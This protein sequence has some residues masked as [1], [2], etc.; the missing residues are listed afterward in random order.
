MSAADKL[1]LRHPAENLLLVELKSTGE[2]VSFRDAEISIPTS[3]S[4]NGRLFVSP[5]DHLDALVS[6]SQSLTT[7]TASNNLILV[8]LINIQIN[9]ELLF[10]C[11]TLV[12]EQENATEGMDFD[13]ELFST[14][15]LAYHM[16]LFDWDL[17]WSVHEVGN[18]TFIFYYKM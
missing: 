17:F 5:K 4:V 11:Q 8:T 9:I 1:G 6:S 14:K 13:M 3:L 2:K 16:T 7:Y 15:E 18:C 10:C 12:P